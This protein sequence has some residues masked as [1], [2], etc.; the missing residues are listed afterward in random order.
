VR[1]VF[2]APQHDYTRSLVAAAKAFDDALE[3][4]P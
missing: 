1:E 2:G 3:G 4:T